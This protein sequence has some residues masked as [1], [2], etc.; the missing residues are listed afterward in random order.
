[1]A[2]WATAQ[3]EETQS[4]LLKVTVPMDLQ[5]VCIDWMIGRKRDI[6]TNEIIAG[7]KEPQS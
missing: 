2:L 4:E 6:A 7:I 3:Q 1:M 5:K